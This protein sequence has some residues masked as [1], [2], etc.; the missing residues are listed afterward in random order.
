MENVKYLTKAEINLI[1]LDIVN[2]KIP[3]GRYWIPGYSEK[4]KNPPPNLKIPRSF[5]IKNDPEVQGIQTYTLCEE[6]YYNYAVDVLTM[7]NVKKIYLTF[8]AHYD[9]KPFS[10]TK[11]HQ[12]YFY[13][14]KTF[15]VQVFEKKNRQRFAILSYDIQGG[16]FQKPEFCFDASNSHGNTSKE[17][18]CIQN[19]FLC[20]WTEE[21]RDLSGW[22]GDYKPRTNNCDVCFAEMVC[23]DNIS[24]KNSRIIS[25]F[26]QNF[27]EEVKHCDFPF[28][29][30]RYRRNRIC[31]NCEGIALKFIV[32]EDTII[33]VARIGKFCRRFMKMKSHD[34]NLLSVI[35]RQ[36]LLT[37][38]F[39][40]RKKRINKLPIIITFAVCNVMDNIIFLNDVEDPEEKK[41]N[42]EEL[43]ENF[44]E[45]IEANFGNKFPSILML[46]RST[47]QSL[48]NNFGNKYKIVTEKQRVLSEVKM[49]YMSQVGKYNCKRSSRITVENITVEN[50][51]D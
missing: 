9:S 14:N 31:G 18:V 11:V 38:I 1:N 29:K 13:H 16:F 25:H 33:S 20:N 46:I 43:I 5:T 7:N 30:N 12:E 2:N 6:I 24:C 15:R 19:C 39:K 37:F 47:F 49:N 40:G 36:E 22:G 44:K 8:C 50:I 32:N 10:V 27:Q 4:F 51:F 21:K 35:S 3:S 17:Y 42:N 23:C 48:M 26:F 45:E 34:Y 28:F 41:K